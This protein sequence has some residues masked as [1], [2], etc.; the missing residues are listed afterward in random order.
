MFDRDVVVAVKVLW[1]VHQSMKVHIIGDSVGEPIVTTHVI[2]SVN[3][4]I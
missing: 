4:D 3:T 2:T 1:E